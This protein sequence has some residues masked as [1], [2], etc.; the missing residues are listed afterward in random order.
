MSD[1]LFEQ[2]DIVLVSLD[3]V[4]GHEQKGVRPAVIVSAYGFHSSGMCLMCPLTQKIKNFYGDIVV[5]P[6]KENNLGKRSEI[7][8]GQIRA[9][10][11]QRIVKKIGVISNKELKLILSGLNVLCGTY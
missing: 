11:H 1:N 9:V 2:R 8:V 7:L 3:P 10:D 6:N 5:E 4:I